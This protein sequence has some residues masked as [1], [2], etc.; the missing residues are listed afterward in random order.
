MIYFAEV[1][2]L[3]NDVEEE[4]VLR[5]NG[6][7]ITCFASVCPFPI[8][9]RAT[10]RVALTPFVFDGYSVCEVS[11]ESLPSLVRVS[12]GFAYEVVGKL[13]GNK[14]DAGC[15]VLEDDVLLSEYGYLDGKM[16]AWK[17]DRIDAEFISD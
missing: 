8:D 1:V 6:V 10:Y 17:V 14:L 15:I 2:R 9:E 4:V 3:N 13:T 5:I 11:G 16:V 7:D 12:S